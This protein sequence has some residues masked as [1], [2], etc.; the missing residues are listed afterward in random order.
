[1]PSSSASSE[2]NDFPSDDDLEITREQIEYYRNR[3]QLK[4][5]LSLKESDVNCTLVKMT[6]FSEIRLASEIIPEYDGNHFGLHQY[7]TKSDK[8]IQ[9]YVDQ[10]PGQE[11]CNLNKL[12]FDI[13]V[14]KLKGAA[15]A[16]VNL[17]SPKTW[18]EVKKVLRANYGDQRNEI[19]IE[20]ELLRCC[21]NLNETYVQYET[22][23]RYILNQIVNFLQLNETSE[24]IRKSK[25]EMYTK[26]A[27]YTFQCGISEPYQTFLRM[28]NPD[29]LEE[30]MRL[31]RDY[32]N[33]VA[34]SRQLSQ[35]RGRSKSSTQVLNFQPRPNSG[36]SQNLFL[37][38]G[39]TPSPSGGSPSQPKF[40]YNAFN[41]AYSGQPFQNH[42]ASNHFNQNISGPNRTP[43][44]SQPV[45]VQ[46]R[47]MPPQ[48][49]FTGQQ[50]FGKPRNV[51][52]PNPSYKPDF[53]PTPMSISTRNT[54][55]PQPSQQTKFGQQ[56]RYNAFAQTGPN[57]HFT[58]KELFQIEN[59]D[60]IPI[61][62]ENTDEYTTEYFDQNYYDSPQDQTYQDNSDE[63]ADFDQNF[64][65]TSLRDDMT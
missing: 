45:N 49:F 50:V 19:L 3:L 61:L 42:Q 11:L 34:T 63:Q 9:M 39:F 12:L 32:D 57:K 47:A 44:P 23:I 55:K 62:Q 8:F 59:T 6:N 29:S 26:K 51:W 4:S 43:F 14:S 18:E 64:M 54:I 46:P 40:F 24:E 21:Q 10:T 7:I 37:N 33:S 17:S 5:N 16:A 22:R 65:E 30:A 60:E 56:P 31:L 27:L 52:K 28:R 41:N 36:S 2:E 20:S 25:I 48:K 58:H 13:V 15:E 38:Q 1:M 53:T 35:F